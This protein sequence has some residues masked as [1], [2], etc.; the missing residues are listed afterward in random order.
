MDAAEGLGFGFRVN[1]NPNFRRI[2][3]AYYFPYSTFRILHAPHTKKMPEYFQSP[4]GVLTH[5]N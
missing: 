2:H 4:T 1:P 3:S 5:S